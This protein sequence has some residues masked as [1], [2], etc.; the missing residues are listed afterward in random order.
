MGVAASGVM[1]QC[2]PLVKEEVECLEWPLL[3]VLHAKRFE[4]GP[5]NLRSQVL[6]EQ[7]AGAGRGVGGSVGSAVGG[8]S[9]ATPPVGGRRRRGGRPRGVAA[10]QSGWGPAHGGA[11]APKVLSHLS[12]VGAVVA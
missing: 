10:S 7:P 5:V 9:G 12:Q 8:G 3:S 11:L 2:Q 6:E 4:G 1:N